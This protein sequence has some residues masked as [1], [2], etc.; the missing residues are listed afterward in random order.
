MNFCALEVSDTQAL[1]QDFI[2][3]LKE[4]AFLISPSYQ[5]NSCENDS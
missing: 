2:T 1:T 3:Y 4:N 5:V